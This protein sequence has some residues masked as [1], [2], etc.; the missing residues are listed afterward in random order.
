M[1]SPTSR[2]LCHRKPRRVISS[3]GASISNM[4]LGR[5][6]LPT[7]RLSG[8][9]IRLRSPTFC[10]QRYINKVPLQQHLSTRRPRH[11]PT[12]SDVKCRTMPSPTDNTTDNTNPLARHDGGMTNAGNSPDP[13]GA[14]EAPEFQQLAALYASSCPRRW[15]LRALM[16]DFAVPPRSSVDVCHTIVDLSTRLGT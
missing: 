14:P 16:L 9:L 10:R 8:D 11:L 12:S 4:G 15:S 5:V 1:L 7:S 2:L 13:E 6:E 3:G